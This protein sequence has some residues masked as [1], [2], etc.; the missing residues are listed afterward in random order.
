MSEGEG[1]LREEIRALLVV[2][3]EGAGP[4]FELFLRGCS[5]VVV[6]VGSRSVLVLVC[7]PPF[8]LPRLVLTYPG[9]SASSTSCAVGLDEGWPVTERTLGESVEMDSSSGYLVDVS[10]VAT[11]YVHAGTRATNN[12]RHSV[13]WAKVTFSDLKNSWISL[14]VLSQLV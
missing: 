4:P 2:F 3:G 13:C 12:F 6:C 1:Q 11:R 9:V 8:K 5:T 10:R 7:L 14:Q